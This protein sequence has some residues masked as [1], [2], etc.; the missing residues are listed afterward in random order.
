VDSRLRGNDLCDPSFQLGGNTL[1]DRVR[2]VG[3]LYQ[4]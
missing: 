1:P 3:M 2:A 4:K